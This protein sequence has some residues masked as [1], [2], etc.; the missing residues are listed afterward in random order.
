MTV[1]PPAPGI[2]SFT[3]QEMKVPDSMGI[4]AVP[5]HETWVTADASAA[6]ANSKTP[7]TKPLFKL[8]QAPRCA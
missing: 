7:K 2:S 1:E 3:A 4:I 5:K 8:N 6:N